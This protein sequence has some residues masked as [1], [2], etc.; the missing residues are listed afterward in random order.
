M[1][2]SRLRNL[3][4]VGRR[5]IAAGS[6]ARRLHSPETRAPRASQA[7]RFGVVD[8]TRQF[9]DATLEE[10]R[11]QHYLRRPGDR[12]V[13]RSRTRKGLVRR[14]VSLGAQAALLAGLWLAGNQVRLSVLTS[15]AFA[16]K[17]VAVRGNQRARTA[18]LLAL[19]SSVLSENIFRADLAKLRE[20]IRRSPWILDASLSRSLPST[21][22]VT[23]RERTPAA[24]VGFE[25]RVWLI[26]AT[27]RRLAEYGPDVAEFDFPVLTGFEGLPRDE[28]A[29]RIK[30]GAGAVEALTAAMPGFAKTVSEVDLSEVDRIAVRPSDGSPVLYLDTK[31][32]LR[33][34]EN[35]AAI[36]G[37]IA[38]GLP[39]RSGL[40]DGGPVRVAYVDLR[41]RGRI[42]VMPREED[43]RPQDGTDEDRS[44]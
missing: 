26:D 43:G 9:G 27:G 8:T 25:G 28:A 24:I 20:E 35:Y 18:D 30:T 7:G 31:D 11:D 13:R 14:L 3:L 37:Q 5:C 42:A 40:D 38:R 6:V 39:G 16:V 15:R 2:V 34:L 19:C 12:A 32:V 21:I 10:R 17:T 22:E 29:R 44:R 23:V 33:N 1:L 36:R 4:A 41:F